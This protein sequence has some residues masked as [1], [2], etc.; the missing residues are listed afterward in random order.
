MLWHRC[1]PPQARRQDRRG[2][3]GPIALPLISRRC[4]IYL[5]AGV[6]RLFVGQ[7]PTTCSEEDLVPVFA[8]YGEIEKVSLVRGPDHKSRGCCMVRAQAGCWGATT[9]VPAWRDLWR[10]FAG[11]AG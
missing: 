5:P 4:H 9:G 7:V 11:P 2:A 6:P 10:A 8:P 1:C 3:G